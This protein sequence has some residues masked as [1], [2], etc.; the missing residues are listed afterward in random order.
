MTQIKNW[1][2]WMWISLS[3]CLTKY[4]FIN[5]VL[6]TIIIPQETKT[7]SYHVSKG[8]NKYSGKP[9][10]WNYERLN[11]QERRES[12]DFSSFHLFS[13][14]FLKIWFFEIFVYLFRRIS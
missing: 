1:I 5:R 14:F 9:F 13:F 7:E 10:H 8:S 6:V 2:S 3:R 4:E 12:V 11:G